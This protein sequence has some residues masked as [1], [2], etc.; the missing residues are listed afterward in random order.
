MAS[1]SKFLSFSPSQLTPTKKTTSLILPSSTQLSFPTL[2]SQC[3]PSVTHT[4]HNNNLGF[5]PITSND[6][7]SYDFISAVY[8]SLANSNILFFKSGYNVQVIVGENEPEEVLLR[9]FRREV[10]KAGVIQ[11]CKRRRTFENKQDKK[12]RKIRDAA[13]RNRRRRPPP[14]RPLPDKQEELKSKKDEHEETDNWELPEGE[15]PY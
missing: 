4:T 14:K 5:L 3:S 10:F 2:S 13:K 8:P 11:E 7:S 12:K 9:R 6:R 1:L 15:L